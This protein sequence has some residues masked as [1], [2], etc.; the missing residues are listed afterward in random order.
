MSL[1]A[2]LHTKPFLKRVIRKKIA[3]SGSKF[4]PY[5]AGCFPEGDRSI[6]TRVVSPESKYYNS[7]IPC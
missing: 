7:W 1:F 3:P 6:L 4:F 2:L 5:K